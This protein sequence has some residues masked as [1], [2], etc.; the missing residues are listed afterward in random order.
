MKFLAGRSLKQ[1]GLYSLL[2]MVFVFL[3]EYFEVRQQLNALDEAERKIDFARGIQIGLQQIALQSQLYMQG[4][5]QIASEIASKIEQ[6]DHQLEIL[7][8]GGRIDGTTEFIEPLSRLPRI[9]FENLA[10]SWTNY[11]T[12]ISG[13]IIQENTPPASPSRVTPDSLATSDSLATGDSL[14][15]SRPAPTQASAI[16]V[17]KVIQEARWLSLSEWFA[18]V[19]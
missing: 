9:T 1:L 18:T 6:Q 8:K 12:A 15:V 7:Q 11:K 4:N 3:V 19:G 16:P 17:S 10:E 5:T 14:N 13:A 2:L